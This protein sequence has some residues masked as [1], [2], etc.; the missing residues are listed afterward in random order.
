[1]PHGTQRIVF[2]F[3]L[4]DLIEMMEQLGSGRVIGAFINRDIKLKQL[5]KMDI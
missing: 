4:T 1:M 3:I 5:L 2:H